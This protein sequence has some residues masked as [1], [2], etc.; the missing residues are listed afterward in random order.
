MILPSDATPGV[1]AALRDL[2]ARIAAIASAGNIDL[3]GRRIINAGQSEG[4]AD[5]VTRA[6]LARKAT[7]AQ[8]ENLNPTLSGLTVRGVLRVLGSL[9]MNGIPDAAIV[10]TRTGGQLDGGAVASR[11]RT[12]RRWD[13]AD[14]AGRRQQCDAVY[15]VSAR[16]RDER[17]AGPQT[18]RRR[19]PSPR[20]G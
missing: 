20:R 4:N 9:F 12:A 8:S 11:R 7:E 17:D 16:G 14:P 19:T 15:V 3:K 10:F 6:E 13:R 2:D 18:L 5:Y 1:I